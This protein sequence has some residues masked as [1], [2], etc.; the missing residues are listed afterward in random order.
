MVEQLFL[1]G[2]RAY[3]ITYHSF[4]FTTSS[5]YFYNLYLSYVCHH[6]SQSCFKSKMVS[7]ALKEVNAVNPK[8]LS[9]TMQSSH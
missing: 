5:K 8:S 1:T 3:L 6:A 7:A 2:N 4:V 9:W